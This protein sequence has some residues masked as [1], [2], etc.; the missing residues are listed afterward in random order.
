MLFEEKYFVNWPNFFLV[1]FIFRDIG[2]YMNCS[3]LLTRLWRHTFWCYSDLSN[4]SVFLLRQKFKYLEN[5]KSFSDEIKSI[6]LKETTPF[7]IKKVIKTTA[8][9]SNKYTCVL[10][11]KHKKAVMQFFFKKLWL[12]SS[13]KFRDIEEVKEL[14]LL[15]SVF[16][17]TA[18]VLH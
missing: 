4:L 17:V 5:E 9:L 12:K 3:F 10:K 2:Q 8:V 16:V 11:K 13:F 14:L 7:F 6:S 18:T 15:T 1:A